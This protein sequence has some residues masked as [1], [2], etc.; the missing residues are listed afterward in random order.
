[1]NDD[2]K[3]CFFTSNSTGI[4]YSTIQFLS[5]KGAK[6]YMAVRNKQK[7]I[8]AIKQLKEEGIEDGQI[9]WLELDLSD[10]RKSKKAAEV[11]LN[12]EERLDILGE[13]YFRW[14]WQGTNAYR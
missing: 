10:P 8:D 6:V 3:F 1:M 14:T 2:F 9:E 13:S 11:F 7:A 12:K 4:G 5:R